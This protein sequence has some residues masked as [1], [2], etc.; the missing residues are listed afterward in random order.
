MAARRLVRRLRRDDMLEPPV[1][2]AQLHPQPV[3][4]EPLAQPCLRRARDHRHRHAAPIVS[5]LPHESP[6]GEQRQARPR[7]LD[8]RLVEHLPPRAWRSTRG[9]LALHP[10]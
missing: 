6:P 3:L 7:R 1:H 10:L 4:H 8:A 5:P 9:L 2:L